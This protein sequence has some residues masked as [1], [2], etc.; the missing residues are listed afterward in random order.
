MQSKDLDQAEKLVKEIRTTPENKYGRTDHEELTKLIKVIAQLRKKSQTS[1]PAVRKGKG[2]TTESNPSPGI[3][4]QIKPGDNLNPFDLWSAY[5]SGLCVDEDAVRHARVWVTIFKSS[6]WLDTAVLAGA[7]PTL[8]G[9]SIDK[10]LDGDTNASIY[11]VLLDWAPLVNRRD[12]ASIFDFLQ[13]HDYD[14]ELKEVHIRGTN[15]IVNI[16]SIID[17]YSYSGLENIRK[18]IPSGTETRALSYSTSTTCSPFRAVR[19]AH[20][21]PLMYYIVFPRQIVLSKKRHHDVMWLFVK[22]P[23]LSKRT[24]KA[25]AE[26]PELESM[27]KKQS[28]LLSD[29]EKV[30]LTM[31]LKWQGT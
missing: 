21:D 10:F 22:Q 1:S 23:D 9:S 6:G 14:Q 28:E 19:A 30:R 17:N 4:R 7:N 2:N 15:I 18:V 20:T 12:M 13:E 3:G 11:L 29:T 5:R 27:F 31:D 16:Q 24:R 25:K 8:V 26:F